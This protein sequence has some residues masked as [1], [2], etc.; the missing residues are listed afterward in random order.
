MPLL[1]GQSVG[2]AS[3]AGKNVTKLA[4]VGFKIVVLGM[5]WTTNG[6][7]LK[8][9]HVLNP[10]T[11]NIPQIGTFHSDPDSFGLCHGT[12]LCGRH[13]VSNGEA[14]DFMPPK[15][16]LCPACSERL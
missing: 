15:G 7:A 5:E 1:A 6:K 2:A 10:G 4:R 8:W 11:Y 3:Q 9:W 13:V 16:V 14:S 12:S